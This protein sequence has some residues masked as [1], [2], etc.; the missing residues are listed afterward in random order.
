MVSVRFTKTLCLKS[1]N[2][3]YRF[4][5]IN[6]CNLLVDGLHSYVNCFKVTV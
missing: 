5:F 6:S 4:I 2:S 1:G 3:F